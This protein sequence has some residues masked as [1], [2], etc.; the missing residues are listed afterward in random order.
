MS[1]P[2]S[3]IICTMEMCKRNESS[4]FPGDFV[5]IPVTDPLLVQD[6]NQ[7]GLVCAKAGDLILWDS[8]CIHC[9]TPA[10]AAFAAQHC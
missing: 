3:Q 5:P 9:N 7:P 6:T 2:K 1:M 8:R 4:K 10:P